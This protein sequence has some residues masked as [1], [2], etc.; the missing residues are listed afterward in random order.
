VTLLVLMSAGSS[1]GCAAAPAMIPAPAPGETAEVPGAPGGQAAAPGG[2][3]ARAAYDQPPEVLSKVDPVYPVI[4]REAGVGGT[5]VVEALVGTDGR[6]G[7]TRIM[8]SIPMLD[9]E[10]VKAVQ[11]WRFKPATLK[12]QSVS[13]WLQCPVQFA[14]P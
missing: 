6:A 12:G 8:K 2:G 4:A 3:E 1:I 14:L 11:Q 9:A 10:A 7:E 5:V 13:A